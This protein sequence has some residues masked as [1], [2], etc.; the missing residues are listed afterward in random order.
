MKRP[1]TITLGE[2]RHDLKQLLERPDDT[3]IYFGAGDLSYYRTKDRGPAEPGA[4]GLVQVE[5]NEVYK[6][7]VG[8][9]DD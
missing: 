2:I 1:K 4:R 9:P 6:I 3:E 5:F 7:T 8:S